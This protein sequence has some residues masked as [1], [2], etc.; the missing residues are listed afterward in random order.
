M[1]RRNQLKPQQTGE[2]TVKPFFAKLT[3]TQATTTISLAVAI[4]AAYSTAAL[5]ANGNHPVF[6]AAAALLSTANAMGLAMAWSIN[7]AAHT[8]KPFW[9]RETTQVQSGPTSATAS[10]TPAPPLRS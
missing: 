10:S 3:S 4:S 2:H 9:Q 1:P 7:R 8:G 6:A 5:A